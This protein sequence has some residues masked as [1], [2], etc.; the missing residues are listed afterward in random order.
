MILPHSYLV[1]QITECH[2]QFVS[3]SF[4]AITG[5]NTGEKKPEGW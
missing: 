1:Y 4:Y 2:M 3:L 5:I